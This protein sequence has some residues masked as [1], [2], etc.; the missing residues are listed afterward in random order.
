MGGT[1][2]VPVDRSRVGRGPERSLA[3]SQRRW[4]LRRWVGVLPIPSAGMSN[5]TV[6]L[7][8]ALLAVVGLVFVAAS[9]ALAIVARTRGLGPGATS[10]RDAVS[11]VALPLGFAVAT[12]C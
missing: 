11:D 3:G 5:D 8:L 12:T 2:Q 1:L 7:F 6:S 10:L 9:A 4:P